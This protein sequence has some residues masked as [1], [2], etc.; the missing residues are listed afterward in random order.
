M[1]FLE[2]QS[3]ANFSSIQYSDK[4]GIEI[5]KIEKKKPA[6]YLLYTEPHAKWLDLSFH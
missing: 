4:D 6:V 3:S 5:M 2:T 1:A